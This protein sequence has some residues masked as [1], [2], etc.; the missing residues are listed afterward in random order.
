MIARGETR[1][2]MRLADY[3]LYGPLAGAVAELQAEAKALGPRIGRATV[4]MVNSTAEGGGVAELLPG[5]VTLLQDLGVRCEWLVIQPDRADF[6]PLTKRIHNLVHGEPV[7]LPDAADCELYA[8]VSES[9]ARAL[10]EHVRPGDIVV[11]HDPQP[12]GAGALLRTRM[13]VKAIWR[14]HIGLDTANDATRAA[15]TFLRPHTDAYDRAVFTLPEYIPWFLAGR[16]TVI[17]PGIDPLS[18]KNRGLSLH[19]HIGI[20]CAAGLARAHWPLLR[21]PF[22]SPA[23]RLQADGSWGAATE[24]DDLGLLHGRILTQVSRWDRLK[25]W[26]PLLEAFR[27]FKRRV[28][29]GE[30]Q[31]RRQRALRSARLVLAG[32][33][34]DSIQ[35]DPEG[36]EVLEE[37][38]ARWLA[39][40]GEVRAQV[41]VLALPMAS[42]KENALMVNA[43]Q[44]ASS[45]VAQNSIREGF[46]LTV[47]EAMWKG[48]PILGNTQAAGIRQQVRDGMDGLLVADPSDSDALSAAIEEMLGNEHAR[49]DWG[50]NGQRRAY[51]EL[52]VFGQLRR[53]LRLLAEVA[54][55]R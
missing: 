15:W 28:A 31:E 12:L 23:R 6:F 42:R 34:P 19:K 35:D 36:V 55:G 27:R 9:C 50:R 24:P 49:E 13:D 51:E 48:I 45:V 8:Q 29:D 46:G 30:S 2:A 16:S 41:A 54:G 18:H 37:I 38:R 25:G 3:M 40:E 47:A 5:V 14:C 4:W 52:L 10:A 43:L 32:P 44:R 53:W 22:P 7:A 20:L 21:P 26:I 11:V 17:H 1:H 33:D 39:L